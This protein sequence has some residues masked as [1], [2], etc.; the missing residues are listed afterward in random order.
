M[1]YLA[2]QSPR[3]KQLLEQIGIVFDTLDI[4]VPERRGPKES[5]L[6]Y[7]QR[8]A[9]DKAVAGRQ[10][11]D[12]AAYV[13]SA[14]TEVCVDDDVLGKPTDDASAIAMLK[15]L[16]GR[17]HEV[18]TAVWLL[19]PD[20]AVRTNCISKVTFG[21]LTTAAIERYVATGE[22][23]GKAGAYG[24]QGRGATFVQHLSG[25]HSAVMGLPL[26]ETAILLEQSYKP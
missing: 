4:D 24:I 17:S 18:L 21:T 1:L 7:V 23:F 10:R 22:C 25:S 14:D 15:R 5:P 13:L 26:Y 20:C 6:A 19:G 3:R 8:V 2:S 12:G 9:R 16:S 11:V